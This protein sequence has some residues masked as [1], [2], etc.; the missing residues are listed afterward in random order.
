VLAES[1]HF[2]DRGDRIKTV[3]TDLRQIDYGNVEVEAPSQL[4]HMA[5]SDVGVVK[6]SAFMCGL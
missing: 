2:E 6:T 1:G 4:R 3:K 5:R